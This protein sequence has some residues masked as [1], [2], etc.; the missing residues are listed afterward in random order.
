LKG[1]FFNVYYKGLHAIIWFFVK[2]FVDT[3][4]KLPK[5]DC[6]LKIAD[7]LLTMEYFIK[8]IVDGTDVTKLHTF[9][10]KKKQKKN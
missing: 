4:Q 5:T 7:C 9:L 1:L 8:K 10:V 3:L 6:V 2:I